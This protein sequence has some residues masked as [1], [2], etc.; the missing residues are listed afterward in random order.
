MQKLSVVKVGGTLL[1][2]PGLREQV[3][4]SFASRRERKILVHGGGKGADQLGQALGLTPR[5]HEGR[6]LTDADTLRVVTMVYG[7]LYNK[8]CVAALQARGC[9]AIGMSGADANSILA[10][11][12]QVEAIDYGFA[13]DIIA[14]QTD[15]LQQLLV[16]GF[17]PV[18]CAL[19]HDGQGQLLNTNADTI[20]QAIATALGSQYDVD[21]FYC[22]DLPGVLQDRG[23]PASRL[24]HLSRTDYEYYR[25]QEVITGGMIPKLDNA[26]RALESGV[27][28]VILCDASFTGTIISSK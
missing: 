21:L 19:T 20:A 18:F 15:A 8:Q 26:F 22:L 24:A 27:Q 5:M 9:N 23:N 25:G 6:R 28:R 13:G 3:F 11:K 14:V 7:G 12:R 4:T 17:C 10:R 1:D 2:E 16:A